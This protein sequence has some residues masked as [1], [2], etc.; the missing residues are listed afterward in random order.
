MLEF[1]ISAAVILTVM[2]IIEIITLLFTLPNH[3]APPY[4]TV[5]PVFCDDNLF[6]NRLD[7]LMQKS[8]GRGNVILVDYSANEH[9]RNL[10]ERFVENNPDAIFIHQQELKKY[11][12][13]TFS[14]INEK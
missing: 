13:K 14:Q 6:E 9:Q 11:L 12:S 5:L 3:N 1:I 10:C 2:A 7:Y 8:C 4:V